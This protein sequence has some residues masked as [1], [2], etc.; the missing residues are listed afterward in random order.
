MNTGL[1]VKI[2]GWCEGFITKTEESQNRDSW[3][4]MKRLKSAVYANAVNRSCSLLDLNEQLA[5]WVEAAKGAVNQKIRE[6]KGKEQ[7]REKQR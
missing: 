4:E 3:I 1:F 6:Q 5:D 2:H 7:K